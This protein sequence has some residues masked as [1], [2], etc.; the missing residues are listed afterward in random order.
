MRVA[1]LALAEAISS[2]ITTVHNWSHTLLSPAYAEAELAVHREVGGRARFAYGYSRNTGPNETLPLDDVARVQRAF[3]G[4]AGPLTLGIASRGVE[5]NTVD[6]CQREW[7]AARKL[8][9]GITTHAGTNPRR[10][11]LVKRIADAVAARLRS[12]WCTPPIPL[13]ARLRFARE[14]GDAGQSE[15]LYGTA[16]RLRHS[17]GGENFKAGVPTGF[18]RYDDPVWQCRHV[19]DHEGDP[20][21]RKRPQAERVRITAASCSGAATMGGAKA[22]GIADRVGSLTPGKRAD[23]IMVRTTD[24]NMAPLTE[25]VRM[26]V[27]SAQPSNIELVMVDGRILKRGSRAHHHRRGRRSSPTRQNN[28]HALRA[29]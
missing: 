7:E 19:R 14:D 29:G 12:W 27:Q 6:I 8:G 16:H 2:G 13:R 26:I 25:P 15:P 23:L 1:C 24:I 9:I 3:H 20:E 4:P 11:D 21:R 22:L 5:N 18:G 10:A 17:A 28:N